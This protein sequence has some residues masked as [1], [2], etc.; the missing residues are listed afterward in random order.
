MIRRCIIAALAAAALGSVWLA[1][2]YRGPLLVGSLRRDLD[3]VPADW[4]LSA[5][6]GDFVELSFDPL[7]DCGSPWLVHAEPW[8]GW[9]LWA[10]PSSGELVVALVAQRDP[11]N[12]RA[13]HI[14]RQGPLYAS[15]VDLP[16]AWRNSLP[17]CGM[18]PRWPA[19]T[20]SLRAYTMLVPLWMIAAGLGLYPLVCALRGPVRRAQRWRNCRCGGCGYDLNGAVA[21]TCPEC[22]RGFNANRLNRNRDR[23]NTREANVIDWSTRYAERRARRWCSRVA[24]ASALLFGV[25]WIVS[26]WKPTLRT[27]WFSIRLMWGDLSVFRFGSADRQNFGAFVE[28]FQGLTTC[29]WPFHFWNWERGWFIVPLWLPTLIALCAWF[30]LYR[31]DLHICARRQSSRF[32]PTRTPAQVRSEPGA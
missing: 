13:S 7:E 2:T 27:P 14:H 22:G 32:D 25:L 20:Y 11:N 29:W 16:G 31:P 9:Q 15:A 4:F 17:H 6:L 10:L 19:P 12:A 26:Y 3:P 8:P 23:L 24:C 1:W 5:E 30:L 21:A 18:A 28:E